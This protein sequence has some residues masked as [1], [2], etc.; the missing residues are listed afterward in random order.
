[1]ALEGTALH[2]SPLTGETRGGGAAGAGEM[3]AAQ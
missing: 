1:M 3:A 2:R